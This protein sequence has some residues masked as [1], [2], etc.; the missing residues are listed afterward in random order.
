[1]RWHSALHKKFLLQPEIPWWVYPLLIISYA[2]R[3]LL[4]IHS[5][6]SECSLPDAFLRLDSFDTRSYHIYSFIAKTYLFD[7]LSRQ[8][9]TRYHHQNQTNQLAGKKKSS[10]QVYLKYSF[11]TYLFLCSNYLRRT[12][13]MD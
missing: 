1:M 13:H 12:N 5:H 6:S 10:A 4:A 8:M 11:D 3:F 7:N 9:I 2:L